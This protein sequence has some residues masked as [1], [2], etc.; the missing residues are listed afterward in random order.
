MGGTDGAGYA[1]VGHLGDAGGLGLREGGVGSDDADRRVGER[2]RHRCARLAD[3]LR[4]VAEAAGLAAGAGDERPRR[5]VDDVAE[6]VH[7]DE[8]GDY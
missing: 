8:G 6:G 1:V 4:A 2:K 5:G 7:G 3:Q